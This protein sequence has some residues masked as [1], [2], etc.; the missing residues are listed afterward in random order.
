[1]SRARF[2]V[3]FVLLGVAAGCNQPVNQDRKITVSPDGK[4]VAIQHDEEGVFLTDPKTGKPQKVFEPGSDLLATSSPR[5]EPAGKRV[6]FAVAK[7]PDGRPA[8]RVATPADGRR[9]TAMTC[10]YSCMLIEDS[11]DKNS[12]PVELF[13]VACDHVGYI[14]ADL[15]V[16]W[17]PDARHIDFIKRTEPGKHS[18]FRYDLATKETRRVF[19]A[20]ADSLVFEFIPDTE[21]R[22]VLRGARGG[23]GSDDGLWFEQ[24]DGSWRHAPDT[25]VRPAVGRDVLESLRESRPAF[26]RSGDKA[27]LAQFARAKEDDS[28]TTTVKV[29]PV[30]GGATETWLTAPGRLRDFHWRPDGAKLALVRGERAGELHLVGP[31]GSAPLAPGERIISFAGWDFAGALFAYV[32][33]DDLPCQKYANSSLLLYPN[34]DARS[35]VIVVGADGQRKALVSGLRATFLNW[36]PNEAKLTLWL[37]FEPSYRRFSTVMAA[38]STGLMGDPAATLDAV[39]GKLDWKAVNGFENVQVGHHHLMRGELAEAAR[40]YEHARPH[41]TENERRELLVFEWLLLKHQGHADAARAKIEE[42]RQRAV[43]I[44]VAAEGQIMAQHVPAGFVGGAPAGVLLARNFAS[45]LERDLFIAEAGLS[46]DAIDDMAAFFRAA[47]ETDDGPARLSD[48]LILANLEMLRGQA[49]EYAELLLK[50]AVPLLRETSEKQK[51]DGA[52]VRT[53]ASLVAQPIQ[54]SEYLNGIPAAVRNKLVARFRTA[55][56]EAKDEGTRK[57]LDGMLYCLAASLKDEKLRAECARNLGLDTP[58][59]EQQFRD[60]AEGIYKFL[61]SGWGK[62]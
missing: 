54:Y 30:S 5:W 49:E 22:Y 32:R 17:H 25:R 55:R 2:A 38:G 37:T 57:T 21:R 58:A 9:Y 41:L 52:Y 33:Q 56:A 7:T 16:R 23:E 19:D 26:T 61:R 62:S 59:K 40:V 36:F 13:T 29:V 42:Y 48:A 15:A 46:A 8:P 12:K 39:T 3:L 14:G 20:D 27:A 44:C 50:W 45:I 47:M 6:I 28:G 60:Q 43:P 31:T 18:L 4:Q 24:P 35:S 10:I 53:M 1:M 11:A 34:A 51:G